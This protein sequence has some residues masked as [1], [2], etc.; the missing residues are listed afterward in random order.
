[1]TLKKEI[2]SET[3]PLWSIEIKWQNVD[4]CKGFDEEVML[5][6]NL[7]IYVK[8]QQYTLTFVFS[9]VEIYTMKKIFSF[10]FW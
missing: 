8:P 9:K 3:N 2:N 4:V 10:S 7:S 6:A 5:E 1:L